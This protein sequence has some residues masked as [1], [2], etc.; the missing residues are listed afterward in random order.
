NRSFGII[1]L[2]MKAYFILLIGMLLQTNTLFSQWTP[3]GGP[4][5]DVNVLSLIN[6]DS[7]LL[8]VTRCG[9]FSKKQLNNEW[10]FNSTFQFSC[11]TKMGDSLF[12]G[13]NY[14]GI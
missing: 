7:F 1:L 11:Y 2:F 6:A 3:T 12:V 5:G 10:T 8:G 14:E 4:Y 13:T 9:Y